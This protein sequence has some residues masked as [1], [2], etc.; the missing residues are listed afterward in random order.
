MDEAHSLLSIQFRPTRSRQG[1]KWPYKGGS[2]KCYNHLTNKATE[3]L[4]AYLKSQQRNFLNY[5]LLPPSMLFPCHIQYLI[6]DPLFYR[7]SKQLQFFIST[8]RRRVVRLVPGI[9]QHQGWK[10]ERKKVN[11]EARGSR[12]SADGRAARP[13]EPEKQWLINKTE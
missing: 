9:C 13:A 4:K 11:R 1:G 12:V 6:E 8:L 2:K 3:R 10:Q 7:L 5:W